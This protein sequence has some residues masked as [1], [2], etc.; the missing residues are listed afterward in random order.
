MVDK[1]SGA[2]IKEVEEYKL[3]DKEVEQLSQIFV[4]KDEKYVAS[5]GNGY[6][7][8][9]LANRTMSR[10]FSIVSNKRVYFRGS[11]LS[12]KGKSLQKSD[13]ERTVDIKDVTGS[14]FIY[15]R[16]LGILLGLFI[17]LLALIGGVIATGYVT[18]YSYRNY[19]S[20]ERLIS[21][22]IERVELGDYGDIQDYSIFKED[23]NYYIFDMETRSIIGEYSQIPAKQIRSIYYQNYSNKLKPTIGYF[24]LSAILLSYDALQI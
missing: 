6:I 15:Q 12:G 24:S 11:C 23:G 2:E 5:L 1:K 7:M 9:Y 20:D 21:S 19:Q 13:E 16:Y 10:G 3:K 18:L 22:I 4:S 8:N 17:A 14:G